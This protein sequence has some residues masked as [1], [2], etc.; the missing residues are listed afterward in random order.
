MDMATK[1]SRYVVVNWSGMGLR[2]YRAGIADGRVDAIRLFERRLRPNER[3]AEF[4]KAAIGA[5]LDGRS[6]YVTA[7]LN[8]GECTDLIIGGWIGLVEEHTDRV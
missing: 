6:D 8:K 4:S 5:F 1:E 3:I 7:Y 2:D